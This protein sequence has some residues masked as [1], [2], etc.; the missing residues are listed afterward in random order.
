[1]RANYS[2]AQTAAL[3][4]L[5]GELYMRAHAPAAQR[6][7][8]GRV[9]VKVRSRRCREC[10][11]RFESY[12]EEVCE[13]CRLRSAPEVH[14]DVLQRL[15]LSGSDWEN[16]AIS[17][18][19]LDLAMRRLSDRTRD[20]VAEFVALGPLALEE[21]YVNFRYGHARHVLSVYRA[22]NCLGEYAQE[23]A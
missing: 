21:S 9:P 20:G 13:T 12:A 17:L 19:D 7:D 2:I 18:A 23:A 16:L 11:K 14:A 4:L 22:I 10:Q 3:L 15:K 5:C 8:P 1:M 6:V